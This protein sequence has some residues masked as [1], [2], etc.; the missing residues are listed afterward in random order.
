MA[1]AGTDRVYSLLDEPQESDNGNVTLVNTSVSPDGSLVVSDTRTGTWAWQ[2]S[3]ASLAGS[4]H[5]T[6]GTPREGKCPLGDLR[7]NNGSAEGG[8]G[9]ERSEAS[10]GAER[11]LSGVEGRSEADEPPELAAHSYLTPLQGL[12]SLTDVDFSYV[13]GKQVLFDIS[14]TAYPGQK[15]AFVGG[16]GAGKTTITNLINR[17]YE[18]QEGKITYDGFDIRD[19]DKDSLRRSLG[20]VLQETCLFS[21]SVLDNIRY[22]R[23]DATDEECVAAARLVYADS[24]IRR[25]PQ[26]YNTILSA[27]GGNLSQGERQLLAIARAAVAD[28]PVLILDEATSSIDTRTEKLIQKGMDSLMKGRTTFVIAHRLSTVQNANYIMVLD[29]GRIIERGRHDELLAQKGK[30][31]ELYTGNQIT[32]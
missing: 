32:S 28:P 17:F 8:I 24:F 18:I 22:G 14:L 13:E 2:A 12:V 29:H 6:L 21:A 5:A 11:S 3:A 4:T 15:I 19:I 27:D 16:T 7:G 10:G 20:I 25:L 26:G 1:S 23:L 9:A 30:Y 31:Y